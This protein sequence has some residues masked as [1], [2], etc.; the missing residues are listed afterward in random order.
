[1]TRKVK[2]EFKLSLP[3]KSLKK[4]ILRR[5]KLFVPLTVFIKK[6]M[7][8]IQNL[9]STEKLEKKPT[10]KLPKNESQVGD[11]SMTIDG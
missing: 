2:S 3:K 8:R 11:F 1:L 10:K 4:F 7:N 6:N 5:L 9:T